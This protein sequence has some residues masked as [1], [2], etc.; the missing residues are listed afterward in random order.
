MHPLIEGFVAAT[1]FAIAV[2]FM[3]DAAITYS[4]VEAFYLVIG[5]MML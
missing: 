5:V 3:I 4:T 2:G 1:I